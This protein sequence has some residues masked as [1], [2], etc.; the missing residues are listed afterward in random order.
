MRFRLLLVDDEIE[1]QEDLMHYLGEDFAYSK[2]LSIEEGLK[3]LSESPD[4]I[5]LDV[6]LDSLFDGISSITKFKNIAPSIPIIMLTRH[7]DYKLAVK[8]IKKGASDYFEKSSATDELK[9]LIYKT[10]ESETAKEEIRY[11]RNEISSLK[12]KLIGESVV[13]RKLRE[14]IE[15]A[16]QME[17]PVLI[18]GETGT[19]KELVA[20]DI[21]RISELKNKPFVAVNVSGITEELFNSELF[22]H[23]RGAFTGANQRKKG[24]FEFAGKGFIFLDEIGYLSPEA[25]VKI[26]RVVEEKTMRRVGGTEDI[27]IPARVLTATNQDIMELIRKRR[28][29]EDLYYRIGAFRIFIP[30]LRERKEDIPLIIDHYLA[31][32]ELDKSIFDESAMDLLINYHWPGNVRQLRNIL[33][34]TGYFPKAEKISRNTVH[35]YL[36][37]PD[38]FSDHQIIFNDEKLFDQEYKI[39]RDKILDDFRKKYIDNIL[40]KTKGNI[41]RAAEISGLSR[42]ALHKNIK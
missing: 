33:E 26:L 37:D 42:T 12:G 20:R 3:K 11:L 34:I 41:T 30:P 8:A 31:F 29:R 25:Q 21:H 5:L 13:M 38:E 22:G 28:F 24:L 40:N 16:A 19:G 32:R 7:T 1:F 18:L 6:E 17:C 35:K 10:I 9:K 4:L 14:E 27:Q 2:A 15:H 23:E 39:S 36:H